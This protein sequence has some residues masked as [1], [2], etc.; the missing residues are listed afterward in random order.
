MN[1]IQYEPSSFL[2][3][4]GRVFH[5][6]GAL[7]RG[8]YPEYSEFYSELLG[9]EPFRKLM[10]QGRVVQVEPVE[11]GSLSVDGFG[12]II[13]VERIAFP[14]YYFEWSMHMLKDAALLT[15]EL[16]LELNNHGIV[17]QDATAFN[18]LFRDTSPVFVDIGSFVKDNKRLLWVAYEQFC[19]FFL[20]P[21]YLY[22]CGYTDVVPRLLR[23]NL[24]GLTASDV[25]NLMS[26][27]RKLTTFGYW[28]RVWFPEKASVRFK[29]KGRESI[30]NLSSSLI[31]RVDIQKMRYRFIKKLYREVTSLKLPYKKSH[32][33]EYYLST[34]QRSLQAK[35]AE[36][37]N[38]LDTFKPASVIDL[39][40][41]T[42]EFSILAAEKGSKVVALDSDHICVDKLYREAK[43]KRLRILPLQI[44][45]LEP[46]PSFG[47]RAMQ[48]PGIT[49][50]IKADMAL[51][52]ALIHHLVFTGG[53]DFERVIMILKDFTRRWLLLEFVNKDDPMAKVICRRV[54]LDYSW[55]RL[56]HL[57]NTM[58]T[59]FSEVKILKELGP[60]RTLILATL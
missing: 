60:T 42:G 51:A 4:T 50:R 31:E 12:L 19:R 52:L 17:L 23:G 30:Y 3:P 25:I 59:H 13:K 40:C 11:P 8:I 28:K 6:N 46:T 5:Y 9:S 57:L 37:S 10:Y 18:I 58:Q 14:T 34:S 2:D 1:K 26:L 16:A 47:W 44:N 55:Y 48:Y 49:E 20:H 54:G 38:I 24:E 7:Y 32:W 27:R 43:E 36:V 56:D 15:L 22:S 45:L 33:S 29:T 39:G 41:N 21:L 35:K 53:Q